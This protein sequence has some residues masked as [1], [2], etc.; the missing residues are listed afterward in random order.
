MNIKLS[1]DQYIYT[2]IYKLFVE[3]LYYIYIRIYYKV[4]Q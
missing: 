1:N 2:S 3:L 4:N